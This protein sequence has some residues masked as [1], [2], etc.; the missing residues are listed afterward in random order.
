[1]DI[2]KIDL[3]EKHSISP[4]LYM[5]FMEPLG[6]SDGSV[7]AAWD[8]I[9]EDWYPTVVDEIKRLAPTMIRFGGAFA[10]YYHWKEGVGPQKDRIPMINHCWGGKYFNQVGTHEV[11]SLCRQIGSEP[12]FVVNMESEGLPFWQYPKNDT[13]RKGTAEEAAEWV[14][15]CNSPDNVL[16]RYHGI[17]QPYNIKYWQVGNETSYNVLGVCG[18]TADTCFKTTQSFAR[19]MKK[20]DDTIRIIGWGDQSTS[21]D[22][23]CKKMSRIDEIDMLAFHHHFGSGLD[24]SPLTTTDYR[25]DTQNTWEHFMNAYKS[26]DEHI[27]KMKA[28]CKSKRLAMTEGHFIPGR[29]RN[30]FLSTWGAGV[31]YARCH[32]TLVRHSDVME[33]ATLADF[34]GNVWQCNALIIQTPMI[35]KNDCYLQP[36]GE[37]MRLFCAH[38]GEKAL[39]ISCNSAVDI[40]A[41]KTGNKVFLHMANTSMTSTAEIKLDL[42]SQSIKNAVMYSITA[43]PATEITPANLG[44]FKETVTQISGDTI[45]LPKAAVAAVEI[46]I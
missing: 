43:D 30:E 18:M 12:L 4:Y 9:E 45:I 27:L 2:L 5:Q 23:W 42:G 8:F 35:E 36:V 7:D 39:D 13:V 22:N 31:A 15:Y 11:A 3:K 26:L 16:R 32:N 6:V 17:Q 14:S 38:K 21:G 29:A 1:M 24:N 20:E 10:S 46:E 37:V 34:M 25:K 28:D 41:S 44:C 33:I 19:A 40:T